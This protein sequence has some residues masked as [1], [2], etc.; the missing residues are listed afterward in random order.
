[1]IIYSTSYWHWLLATLKRVTQITI[2]LIHDR[3][4]GL[5]IRNIFPDL[6][7]IQANGTH[8]IAPSPKAMSLKVLFQA[9]IFLKDYHGALPFEISYYGSHRIFGGYGQAHMNMVYA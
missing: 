4:I 1:M 2:V 3:V 5:L 7:F 6:G 8:I 9:A